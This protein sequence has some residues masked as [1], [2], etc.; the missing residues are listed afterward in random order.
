MLLFKSIL[1]SSDS[2]CLITSHICFIFITVM[3][4]DSLDEDRFSEGCET[5]NRFTQQERRTPL[6]AV[7]GV[8]QKTP[9]SSRPSVT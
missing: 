2:F 3:D 8:G 5:L 6:P 7:S 4:V 9:K 1:A